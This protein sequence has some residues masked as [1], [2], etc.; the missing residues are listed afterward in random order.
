MGKIMFC[1][2]NVTELSEEVSKINI[3]VAKKINERINEQR[4]NYAIVKLFKSE[5]LK[6]KITFP[7]ELTRRESPDFLICTPNKKIG[8]EHTEATYENDKRKQNLMDKGHGKYPI[9]MGKKHP[10]EPKKSEKELITEIEENNGGVGWMGNEVETNWADFLACSIEKKIKTFSK[11]SFEKFDENW[12][13]IYDNYYSLPYVELEEAM[14]LLLEKINK[15]NKLDSFNKIFILTDG[16]VYEIY[17][18]NLSNNTKFIYKIHLQS[19][20]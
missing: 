2:K 4:E 15:N 3:C 13:L 18:E 14:P 6:E 8:I 12:L 20:S 16:N 1:V 19:Q 5:A 17:S 10:G 7:L 11:D 9:Y